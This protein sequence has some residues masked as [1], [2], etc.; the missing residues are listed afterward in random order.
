MP[1]PT[2]EQ[3]FPGATQNATGITIP[4]T[5]LRTITPSA[6]NP[7]DRT[8]AGF[9]A[10]C[11][12][13]YTEARRNGDSAANPPTFGDQD[14]SVIVEQGRSSIVSS[15]DAQNNR[16]EYEELEMVFRFYK[17]RPAGDFDAD[18]Y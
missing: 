9:V 5:A 2:L 8:V 1:Q 15:F 10:S 13:F 18:N 6:T 11:L 7:G 12:F 16:T 17:L 3:I 14:V 4:W